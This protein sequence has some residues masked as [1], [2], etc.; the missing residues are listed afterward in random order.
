MNTVAAIYFDG[1]TSRLYRVE[2]SVIGDT[3]YVREIT[4]DLH[5]GITRSCPLTE[6]RVSERT[7][8]APRKVTFSDGAYLEI[9]D[10][11]TFNT[12]LGNTGYQDS[13]VVQL[14]QSWTGTLFALAGTVIV[15]TLGYMYGLPAASRVVAFATPVSVERKL[16]D[17]M[18]DF[19]DKHIFKPSVLPAA[20]QEELSAR[21]QR[22]R[23]PRG[24]SPTYHLVFRKSTI[25]PNAFALPSGDIIVTDEIIKL[26]NDDE[27]IM[28]VLAHELGHLHERHLT[29]RIIQSSAVGATATLLF[30]D[31]SAVVANIPTLMLDLKYSRDAETEA[32]DYAMKMLDANGIAREHL[33]VAFEKLDALAPGMS[34]YLSSHPA[35]SDRVMRIRGYDRGR[36]SDKTE[37]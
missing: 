30:G 37:P 34:P 3:A 26:M 8:H 35:G 32:D 17:G 19:L 27:A 4:N 24:D 28:G 15:L 13:T 20:R 14:Q 23:P 16:G 25:G 36:S 9:T 21:F 22:L 6:L 11:A 33:A 1:K 10:H 7:R 18:L 12:M 5:E 31:V 29:R 2:F